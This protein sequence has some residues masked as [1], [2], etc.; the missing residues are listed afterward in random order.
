MWTQ[1][2]SNARRKAAL[3][4]RVSSRETAKGAAH[5]AILDNAFWRQHFNSVP[6]RSQHG[7]HNIDSPTPS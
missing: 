3:R 6:I 2:L 4:P 5:V 7:R 1:I